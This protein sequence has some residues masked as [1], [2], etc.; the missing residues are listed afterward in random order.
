ML[1]M[2]ACDVIEAD[3][4]EQR[5]LEGIPVFRHADALR[6]G[7]ERE[8]ALGVERSAREH[9]GVGPLRA[10]RT[11][12]MDRRL[13]HWQC[14]FCRHETALSE[15]RDVCCKCNGARLQLGDSDAVARESARRA[16]RETE[17]HGR[18]LNARGVGCENVPRATV[19]IFEQVRISVAFREVA[20]QSQCMSYIGFR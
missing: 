3:D 1:R 6:P 9:G 13:S 12:R 10:R 11:K 4:A 14:T 8:V 5:R 16:A 19:G 2:L 18:L 20:C 15:Q 7:A 17:A